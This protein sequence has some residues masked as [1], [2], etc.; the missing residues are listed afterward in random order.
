MKL[1]CSWIIINEKR[2]L[3]I[4]RSKNKGSV[5]NMWIFPG[6]WHEDWETFEQTA[7]R[8]VK[9]EVW[10]QFNLEKLYSNDTNERGQYYQYIGTWDW[11][12]SLQESECDW[13]WWFT[14]IEAQYL[15]LIIKHKEILSKLYE[16]WIIE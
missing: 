14:Y 12:V 4:K 16:E 11:K 6:G 15:P 7:I 1:V 9:E 13:Y 3:L 5:P 2:V 10:L 8:E